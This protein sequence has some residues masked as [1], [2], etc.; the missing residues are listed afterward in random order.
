MNEASSTPEVDLTEI[1]G[2]TPAL[3]ALKTRMTIRELYRNGAKQVVAHDHDPNRINVTT[4]A[5]Y[6]THV[7]GIG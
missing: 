7:S 6:I 4:D 5:G 2:M 3:A 1:V